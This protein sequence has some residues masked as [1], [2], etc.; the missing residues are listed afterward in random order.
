MASALGSRAV[1]ASTPTVAISTSRW[2]NPEARPVLCLPLRLLPV[3]IGQIIQRGPKNH[4]GRSRI[5]FLRIL[6]MERR[7][8]VP[9]RLS[10][11]LKGHVGWRATRRRPLP[12]AAGGTT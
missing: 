6:R 4:N 2:I 11:R 3:S 12:G 10:E 8:R 5:I 7:P 9:G 1:A